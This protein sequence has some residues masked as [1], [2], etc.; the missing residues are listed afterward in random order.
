[1]KLH[2]RLKSF[3]IHLGKSQE[4]MA[5]KLQLTVMTWQRYETGKSDIKGKILEKL[6]RMGAS[7]YWLLAGKGAITGDKMSQ[8]TEDIPIPSIALQSQALPDSM[9]DIPVF[10]TILSLGHA[11]T[12][13][14]A[15]NS[16]FLPMPRV[17][18]EDCFQLNPQNIAALY[19]PN[20]SMAP[21]LRYGNLAII[22]LSCP[23]VDMKGIY[24]F[25][26][27]KGGYINRL[28]KM[29]RKIA[30]NGDNPRYEGWII[31]EIND[32]NLQIFGRVCGVVQG[33]RI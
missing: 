15:P 11:K 18:L 20:D 33:Q 6:M 14:N 22:D 17:I 9:C 5:E 27:R 12:P 10:N 13:V 8:P 3:R 19:M 29:A 2:E 1:M 32:S 28:Q 21:T 4:E 26:Y 30:V 31:E 16:S 23:I 25:S 24:A 7:P